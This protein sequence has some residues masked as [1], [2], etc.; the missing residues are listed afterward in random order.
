MSF[1]QQYWANCTDSLAWVGQE[2]LL[3]GNMNCYRWSLLF[4]IQLLIYRTLAVNLLTIFLARLLNVAYCL[5]FTSVLGC[6]FLISTWCVSYQPPALQCNV[7]PNYELCEACNLT[8]I[9][10]YHEM[11]EVENEVRDASFP[12]SFTGSVVR[13]NQTARLRT[14]F[15]MAVWS[16]PRDISW[17]QWIKVAGSAWDI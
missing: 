4:Y 6:F 7:C 9:H 1:S 14:V 17:N 15:Q 11:N 3:Q 13:S 16:A 10:S 8:G 2:I 5:D 12:G